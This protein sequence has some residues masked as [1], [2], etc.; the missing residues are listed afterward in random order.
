MI[1]KDNI[2]AS[3]PDAIALPTAADFRKGMI[4]NTVAMAEDVNAYGNMSDRD[5]WVVCQEIMN[6]M[7]LFEIT[8]NDSY[9]SGMQNQLANMF[10]ER[11]GT[12]YS[13]TGIDRMTYTG[14]PVQSDDGVSIVFTSF[15][16]VYN[17]DVFY[18]NTKAQHQ[19]TTL[20][21]QSISSG[22]LTDGAWYVYAVTT[23]G[24][25]VSTIA[26][27]QS[28]VLGSEGA[29]KC[30]L[31]TVFVYNG[32][33]QK[34]TWKF[35]PWLQIT[36]VE[37]REM[38]VAYTKGGYM[39]PLGG[40][41][42]QM[43]SLE[44]LAE[45]I[46]FDANPNNPTIKEIAAKAP[47]TYKFLRPAYD[48]GSAETSEIDTL[49]LYNMT[50]KTWDDLTSI[51]EA[52]TPKYMVMVPCITPAGQTL[53]IPAMSEQTD[54]GYTQLYNSMNDARA[55]IFG[56]KYDL[57][58]VALRAIYLGQSLIVRVGA[59]D[60]TD[61]TQFESVGMLPQALT[62][63]TAAGGQAGGGVGRYIPMQEVDWSG[64][65]T[66]TCQNNAS[67]IIQGDGTTPISIATPSVQT[68]IVNQFEIKYKHTQGSQGIVFPSNIKW[69]AGGEPGFVDGSTYL[70]VVEY[71][72]GTWW[73]GVLSG[74]A[75]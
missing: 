7:A 71:T 27:Q 56:L 35:Q 13:L 24:S 63:F 62:G 41:Q 50:T 46:N 65:T 1:K 11:V 30:M 9:S 28:P 20:A 22:G 61:S 69:W 45:G 49:H 74:A 67:N 3:Q 40:V 12:S 37:N 43:G 5:L 18:G 23:P 36:A 58:N 51:A 34:D 31:G 64:Y 29:T 16:I 10:S 25:N 44:I 8:P 14:A 48:P 75:A 53:M 19:R 39:G 21:A 57:Q 55:A 17:L 38:P 59:T 26:F 32:R 54:E 66:V 15:D 2:F 70:I 6:L 52:P 72:A 42:L 68:G 73:A 4:P 47:Y 33:F 60:L